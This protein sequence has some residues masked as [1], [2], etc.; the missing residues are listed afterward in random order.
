MTQIITNLTSYSEHRPEDGVKDN[1]A[2]EYA[3][4]E[5]DKHREAEVL[6]HPDGSVTPEKLSDGL[7]ARISE[8]Y[9]TAQTASETA[10]TAK[11]TAE[12]ANGVAIDAINEAILAKGSASDAYSNSAIA[13]ATAEDALL[14]AESAEEK[15]NSALVSTSISGSVANTAL[16]EA[17]KAINIASGA[18]QKAEGVQA[19][20]EEHRS[21]TVIHT[22]AEEKA[23]WNSRIDEAQ[24]TA[25]EASTKADEAKGRLESLEPSFAEWDHTSSRSIANETAIAELQIDVDTKAD[26]PTITEST[27]TVLSFEFSTNHNTEIRTGELTTLSFTFGNGEYAEDYASGL[28]FDSGE[29]PTA[30]DYTDSGILN[31]VG[32]DCVTSDGLSIFQ[33]SANTHY[34]IVF[35]FNGKQFIGL[36]NGYVPAGGNEA[37]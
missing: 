33:P 19:D 34:D 25:T 4:R 13:T 31:W 11:N 1:W 23:D 22:T 2:A 29:T 16:D 14:V 30:I 8:A 32:T 15:A 18:V 36:V 9:E 24:L 35:Y 27:D 7:R 21:D 20:L 37:V 26:K 3:K 10:S 12:V 28:S 5:V 17:V 6:D